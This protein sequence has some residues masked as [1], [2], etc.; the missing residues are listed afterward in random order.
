MLLVSVRHIA[1]LL[2]PHLTSRPVQHSL[3]QC[4][5]THYAP[6]QLNIS[7][8]ARYTTASALAALPTCTPPSL[9]H[10]HLSDFV[11][12]FQYEGRVSHPHAQH[13]APILRQH[14][15]T[16]HQQLREAGTDVAPVG[17]SVL[18]AQPYL[19]DLQAAGRYSTVQ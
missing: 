2:L 5:T 19:T 16:G 7:P 14:L 17:T 3:C 9:R 15:G 18:T 8:S 10:P 12:V 11:Q 6:A 1:L 4:C 13:G